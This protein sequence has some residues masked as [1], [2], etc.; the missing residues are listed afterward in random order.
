MLESDRPS[1]SRSKFLYLNRIDHLKVGQNFHY[2]VSYSGL[3]F[4]FLSEVRPFMINFLTRVPL[5]TENCKKEGLII[6][7]II[8]LDRQ[9]LTFLSLVARGIQILYSFS[10]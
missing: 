1:K 8:E 9:N 2:F 4:P 5:R 6:F 7:E 10:K 3:K